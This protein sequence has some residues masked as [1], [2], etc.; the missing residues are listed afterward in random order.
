MNEY[1]KDREW[2]DQYIPAIQKIVG[3]H[4]LVPAPFEI[5]AKKATDLIVLRARDMMIACR[6]PRP[7]KDGERSYA[8]RY[9][10]QFTIRSHRDSGA[11][12]EL[13]KIVDGWG[14]WMFYAHAA[15]TVAAFEQWF[16]VNLHAWRAHMIRSRKIIR[17]GN[18]S[19]GDGTH[20]AWFDLRSFPPKPPIL[21]ASSHLV[22]AR[23]AA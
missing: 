21:I 19:N 2:S 10:D 15:E 12:T 13:A 7:A 8:E 23:I 4:L 6:V 11:E 17:K 22:P 1:S 18:Q 20:F 5:D 16:L 9:P 14:D 3:P